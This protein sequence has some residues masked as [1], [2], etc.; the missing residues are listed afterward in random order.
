MRRQSWIAACIAAVLAGTTF[1]GCSKVN[2][3]NSSRD[4][5]APDSSEITTD[6]YQSR[7]IQISVPPGNRNPRITC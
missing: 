5:L 7:K 1:V 2:L 4:S 6:A 3:W